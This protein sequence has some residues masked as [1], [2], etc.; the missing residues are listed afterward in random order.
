MA[1]KVAVIVGAGPLEGVGGALALRASAAGHHVLIVGRT[2]ARI[3]ALAKH[4]RCHNGSATAIALDTTDE[5]Q[6]EKLFTTID[7][8]D[9][10]LDFVGV[11]PTSSMFPRLCPCWGA[12]HAGGP[13]TVGR[14][15]KSEKKSKS[16][17]SRT[18]GTWLLTPA[19]PSA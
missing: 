16:G 15:P 19:R 4:L 14:P 12:D 17:F 11:P 7:G 1:E 5:Q 13:G 2:E 10:S 3:E 8:M 18:G 6:V 9:G